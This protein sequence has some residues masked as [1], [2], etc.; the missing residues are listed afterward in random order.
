MT[1]GGGAY[2][3]LEN[4]AL[5]V[6]DGR[7]AWLGPMSE[8]PGAPSEMASDVHDLDGCWMTPGLID[9]HTHLV[10]GGDRAREF[11][12]RLEGASYEELAKAG[13]G[14]L[15][16]VSATRDTDAD[17]LYEAAVPRLQSLMADG[18]TTVEIKSGYGLSAEAEAKQLSVA[19]RLGESFPVEVVTT[20]LGAHAI[21]PEFQDDSAGY[22]DEVV[23]RMLP[24]AHAEGLVDMVDAF[25]ESIAFS[26]EETARVFD[27]AKE[28]GLPLKLHADQLSDLNGAA[29]A[30]D[31]GALSAEH[32]EWTNEAG[33]RAMA[34]TG[35]VAVLLPGAFYQL[36]ETKLPPI[37]GFRTAGVPIA[38]ATDC[39][40]GSA[41]VFSL[42]L[43][44]NMACILFRLTPEEA[45]AGVTRNAARALGR[46]DTVGTLEEGKQADLCVWRI[47]RPADL[48]YR[49][50]FNPLVSR[51]KAGRIDA[52]G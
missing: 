31:Y 9:C 7:I 11:E 19:R 49:I 34:K 3:A 41:P 33:I 37:E 13:G 47:S 48:A 4:A 15:S 14:I 21:P 2:G 42:L 8:L 51:I 1:E 29:L 16:T 23:Q 26:P 20:F 22:I 17:A 39:N 44:L 45:L 36:R 50:G 43:M 24:Q 5:A 25:C 30:A 52:N 28:L 18:V 46:S 27:K 35:T 40:P 38:I 12:L 6:R 10:W 32:L